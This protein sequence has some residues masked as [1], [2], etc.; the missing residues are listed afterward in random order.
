MARLI[1][2]TVVLGAAMSAHG[3]GVLGPKKASDLVTL[4]EGDAPCSFGVFSG[5]VMDA[6]VNGDGTTTP[7][8]TIPPGS[9]LVL[10][11]FS[12]GEGYLGF[13][14]AIGTPGQGVIGIAGAEHALWIADGG[15]GSTRLPALTVKSGSS[16]CAAPYLTPMRV[17]GFLAPDK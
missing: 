14:Y 15:A 13:G 6:R 10:D 16:V 1:I 11:A 2:L 3:G 12:F 9:V 8:F 4:R 7:G 17:H 5:V